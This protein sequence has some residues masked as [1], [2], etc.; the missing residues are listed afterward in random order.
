ML[1]LS[2]SSTG[3]GAGQG[4]GGQYST[5]EM[6]SRQRVELWDDWGRDAWSDYYGPRRHSYTHSSPGPAR[7]SAYQGRDRRPWPLY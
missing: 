6:D 7:S 4:R 5:E 2:E 3:A 1:E